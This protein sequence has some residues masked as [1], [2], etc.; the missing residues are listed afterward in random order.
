MSKRVMEPHRI[1]VAVVL[2]PRVFYAETQ[3]SMSFRDLILNTGYCCS[4]EHVSVELLANAL[5]VRPKNVEDWLA[6]S[7]NKRT[8][9]GWFFRH[10][11]TGGFEVGYLPATEDRPTF[12][13]TKTEVFRACAKF[14][15]YEID[16]VCGGYENQGR[17]A[18]N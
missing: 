7:D 17:T 4:A 2:I 5:R 8:D 14:I 16:D 3:V 10:R 13:Y 1:A 11:L 15:K 18:G 6:W 12:H 9:S